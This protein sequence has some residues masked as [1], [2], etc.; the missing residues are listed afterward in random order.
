MKKKNWRNIWLKKKPAF[1]TWRNTEIFAG[2]L[3]LFAIVFRFFAGGEAPEEVAEIRQKETEIIVFGTWVPDAEREILATLESSGDVDIKADIAGTMA[4]VLVNIGDRVS[5][6]QFLAR[7]QLEDDSTQA[8]YE[9][10]LRNLEAV[11]MSGIN[12]VRSAEITLETAERELEQTRLTQEQ[13]KKQ[14]FEKLRTQSVNSETTASNALDWADRILGASEKFQFRQDANDVTR[15]HIGSNNTVKR[16][17]LKNTVRLLVSEKKTLSMIPSFR[18]TDEDYFHF[19]EERLDFLRSMQTIVREIDSLI[20]QTH[21]SSTKFTETDRSTFQTEAE[22]FS[23]GMDAAILSLE[24]QFET[25][26]T[27][28][29]S[30]ELSILTSENKVE[31]ARAALELAKVTSASQIATAENTLRSARTGQADLEIRAPFSGKVTDKKVS[32]FQQVQSGDTLFSLVAGEITPRVTAYVTSDELQRIES[33]EEIQIKFPNDG[34]VTVRIPNLS[35][36]TDPG[37]QKIRVEFPLDEFPPNTLVGS[38]ARLILPSVK[39]GNRRLLPIS[40]VSF[41]PD[42]AEVLILNEK[43]IAERRKVEYR[44]ILGDGIEI[45]GGLESGD[46]VVRYRSRVHAGEKI[47]YQ[48]SMNNDQ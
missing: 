42:G 47:K 29:Q 24:S 41:E 15:Q 36:K 32:A 7:F 35:S 45:S 4:Q 38:F 21:L 3:L 37:S 10:A 22:N 2:S 13:T 8:T 43:H 25:A 1:F 44:R 48:S 39:N 11:R 31:N 30:K 34:I 17:E 6:N 14:V 19:A 40:A 28:E 16:Q 18:P 26:K 9:N 46:R 20:R 27:Q 23:S 33:S 5:K 12:T